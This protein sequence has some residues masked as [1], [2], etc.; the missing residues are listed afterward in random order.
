MVTSNQCFKKYGDPSLLSTQIEFF[1]VW[2]VPQNILD[3]FSHVR[4]SA[5]G[6]LGFPKKIFINKDFRPLLELALLNVI[7]NKL[8]KE[9]KT[10]DGCFIIREKRGL[11]SLSLH[12]WA[13]AI[14]L[15]AFENGLGKIPKLSKAFV[16]C[17]TD[18]G[19]DWGGIW[20]RKDGMHFQIKVLPICSQQ[21][22]NFYTVK[23]GDSLSKI[24]ANNN[25]TVTKLMKENNLT[26][27]IIRVGQNITVR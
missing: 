16:K 12:S 9:L 27:T 21:N 20:T 5:V 24:A 1:E 11:N 14:D 26:S 15:N 4:L 25:T 23:S 8:T 22:T 2:I 13:V 18:V 17:F 19:M 6:T 3:A 7:S 10:W